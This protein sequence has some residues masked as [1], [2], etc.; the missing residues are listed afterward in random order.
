MKTKDYILIF[1]SF[2][3]RAYSHRNKL[4][5]SYAKITSIDKEVQLLSL[6]HNRL[7]AMCTNGS[8]YL[9]DLHLFK[10]NH[11]N[12]SLVEGSYELNISSPIRVIINNMDI[13]PDCVTMC[14]LTDLHAD[15][16]NNS[17][18]FHADSVN[19]NQ[20]LHSVAALNSNSILINICGRLKLLEMDVDTTGLPL[21]SSDD[22][23]GVKMTNVPS[24]TNNSSQSKNVP[25]K[26]NGDY[27]PG[28]IKYR[29]VLKLAS[30]VENLWLLPHDDMQA[31]V[32]RSSSSTTNLIALANG[33]QAQLR[34]HLTTSLYLSCG[35]HGM[36]IWLTLEQLVRSLYTNG[37]HSKAEQ[38]EHAYI[39]KR[40]MLPIYEMTNHIYPLAV[41]FREAIVLGAESDSLNPD[42]MH[43]SIVDA[44]NRLDSSLQIPF[45]IV[46]RT[47]QVY[48]HYILRE[49]LRKNLGYRAWEIANTCTALPHFV[50]SLELLLHGVLE[51]EASSSQPI[52][53]ALLPR[54]V[55]FIRAFP[56]FL[57][58]VI[59]CT[60]KTELALWPHLFSIVGS[61]KDLFQ[62]CISEGQLETAA[63]YIIVLQNLEKPEVATKCASRLLQAARIAGCWTTVKEL[64]R[65]LRATNHAEQNEKEPNIPAVNKQDISEITDNFV[66]VGKDQ[67]LTTIGKHVEVNEPKICSEKT[68]IPFAKPSS[69]SPPPVSL[70]SPSQLTNAGKLN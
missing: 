61:P 67:Q 50:H 6:H 5:N 41:R 52:P 54:V 45:T 69:S 21:S 48:L 37:N 22:E 60:R 27:E 57:K 33:R 25:T 8:I 53:D 4:D 20:L 39:S 7:L 11:H 14:L 26:V 31:S 19:R 65:F 2:E 58:T 43:M 29:M 30:N 63:S 46:K 59:H 17:H 47:S 15:V 66:V 36:H 68:E 56:V 34:P 32:F 62:Q 70:T 1:Y 38:D 28:T 42:S 10:K 23:D 51:E 49:L 9:F 40:I 24:N 55:E 16:Y 64:K 18:Q 3:I 12:T 44:N 13:Y 35:V